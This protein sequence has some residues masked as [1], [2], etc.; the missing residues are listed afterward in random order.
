MLASCTSIPSD[1]NLFSQA[2]DLNTRNN[3]LNFSYQTS[4]AKKIE[5]EE[6]NF[7]SKYENSILGISSTG[8]LSLIY[9]DQFYEKPLNLGEVQSTLISISPDQK[10]IAYLSDQSSVGTESDDKIIRIITSTGIENNQIKLTDDTNLLSLQWI[11]ENLL[12][13]VDRS[14]TIPY[15]ILDIQKQTFSVLTFSPS[16]R[17]FNFGLERL[18]FL[19]PD[20]DQMLFITRNEDLRNY[21]SNSIISWKSLEDLSETTSSLT[22]T[23]PLS[24]HPAGRFIALES[25]H[26][27]QQ[28]FLDTSPSRELFIIDTELN[29]Y[30]QITDF[31]A[32]FNQKNF[33]NK[34]KWS[35][36]GQKLVI[37]TSQYEI[38]NT[39]PFEIK[40]IDFESRQI[41]DL[42]LE[43]TIVGDFHW[44]LDN[45][46][47]AWN[48]AEGNMCVLD[49]EIYQYQCD[50]SEIKLVGWVEVKKTDR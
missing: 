6:F 14:K 30:S 7:P 41:T 22:F 5:T 4:C 43:Q 40:L 33:I 29:K 31:F 23:G 37:Q 9:L 2:I 26:I 45:K 48:Q 42:C 13:L 35:P 1:E 36:T 25:V 27:D 8:E 38:N 21:F 44:S 50:K 12:M 24:W 19:S 15:R 49:T 20:G 46:Y 3:S 17:N 16:E 39:L 10:Q 18:L 47:L 34:L 28:S 11:N 32:E